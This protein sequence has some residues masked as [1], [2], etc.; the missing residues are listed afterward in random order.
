MRLYMFATFYTCK[1]LHIKY[2]IINNLLCHV[3]NMAVT[4]LKIV[5]SVFLV[6]KTNRC[7]EF[8]F[9]WYLLLNMFRA[10]F[11]PIIRSS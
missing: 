10:A 4:P 11:L 9:Y 2:L 7:T 6:N 8:Q 1:Y 3:L 5:L